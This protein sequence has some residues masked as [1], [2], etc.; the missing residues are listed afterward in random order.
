MVGVNQRPTDS[1]LIAVTVGVVRCK[2]EIF[3]SSFAVAKLLE[4]I[5]GEGQVRGS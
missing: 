3:R 5:M 2:A 4:H 1:Q